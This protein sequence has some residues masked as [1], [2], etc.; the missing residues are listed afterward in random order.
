MATAGGREVRPSRPTGRMRAGALAERLVARRLTAAGW[1]VLA[2][3]LRIGRSELD[4]VAVD[5]GPPPQLVVVEVR[6]NR[7][8]AFGAPEERVD[9]A[10]M[11]AVYRGALLLRAAGRLPDGTPLPRLPLRVDVIAVELGTTLGGAAP[12]SVVRHL[13]GVTA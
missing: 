5:P 2:T 12:G 4:V 9:R 1:R 7:A 3:D 8:S 6:A 13:R 10:K 11:H